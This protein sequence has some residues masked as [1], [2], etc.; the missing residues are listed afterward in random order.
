MA[1]R[2]YQIT[3]S[4]EIGKGGAKTK[5]KANLA[6]VRLLKE[7]EAEQRQATPD[8]QA[9]L[10]KFSGWGTVVDIFTG[11]PEWA[12]LQGEL[13]DLLTDA[14]YESASAAILN[15]HYTA[16]EVTTAI[17]EGLE[18]LGFDGGKILDPSMG[19]TGVFEGTLPDSLQEESK[20]VGIELDSLSGRIARKLYPE[21]AIHIRGFEKTVL[22]DDSFDLA[23]SNVPFSEVGVSDPE[24]D[25]LPV[26]TLHDYFFVK[27][28]D[29]VRPG[30]LTAFITSIGTMQSGSSE[31]VRELLSERANLVGAMRLPGTAFKQVAGTEVTTDLIVLQK[32]GDGVEPNGVDWTKLQPS[33]V[34]GA[35]GNALPVNEYYARNPQMMLGTLADDKLYPGRLAL[36]GD[37]RDIQ[38]AMRE[39]FSSFPEGIYQSAS[40]ATRPQQANILIPPDLQDR[41]KPDA[42][43]LHEDQLMRRMGHYLKPTEL[44]GK[45]LE[46]MKGMLAIRDAVQSVF[47]VQLQGGS[48]QALQEAQAT[49][50]QTYDD[51]TKANGFIHQSAN[52][53]IF[54]KDPDYPLLLALENYDAE[55]KTATKT[56]IFSDR[57]IQAH[58]EKTEADTPKEA[59][60]YSL[61]ERGRVD[62]DYIAGL[63]D[64]SSA[65]VTQALQ[66]EKLIFLDPQK[67][68]WVAEDEYL[69]GN[70]KEKLRIA[71]ESAAEDPRYAVNVEALE[72]VQP[73]LIPPG[74]IEVRLGAAWVPPSDVQDF[75]KH[76]LEATD[77][78]NIQYSPFLDVWSVDAS[79]QVLGSVKNTKVYGTERVGALRLIELGLNLKDPVV[80]DKVDERLVVNQED[81]AA[82]RM[83]LEE[84]KVAFKDWVWQ[85]PARTERLTDLYNEKFNTFRPRQYNGAHL[86]LP[87][88]NPAIQ[89]RPHQKNATWRVLQ[90][91]NSLLAH[92]VGAGKTFSVIAAAM[93]QKR[94]GLVNK[95]MVVV[96]NHLLEQW[97]GDFKRLYPNS[98]ILAATKDDSSAKNRQE[99]MS[100]IATGNWDAVIVTHSA[101]S[102]LKM[103]KDAQLDFYHAELSQVSE[104]ASEAKGNGS[105]RS[106]IKEFERQKK[107]LQKR[108]DEISKSG[109]DD[110]VTFEQLGVDQVYID[111]A[112]YFKNLGYSTKM[113]GIAGLPNTTSDRAFDLFM[114][115]RYLGAQHGESKGVVFATGTPVSNSMA[116]L[117]TMQRYLQPQ[118]LRQIGL[119][120]FDAW[121]S[122]FGETV[123][124]PEITPAGGY[125][126]KTRFSRF[127]NIP[128]LM[129]TFRQVADIQT[130][131]MLKLPVPELKGGKPEVVAVPATDMQLAFVEELA[132]RAE[133][134]RDVDPRDDNMLLI[135][136]DGRKASLDMR[137]VN[138]YVS[139]E[140]NKVDQLIEDTCQFWEETKDQKTTHLIFCDMGTPKEDAGSKTAK[141]INVE[142]QFTVYGYIKDGLIARGIPAS[143]IA[144]AQE[145]KTDAKKLEMQQKFN[146]GKI[147]VLISGSQLETGF[148]GQKK[149]GLESHLTVPWRPDQVEQRDGR[150]LR[151][152]NENPEVQVRR[153]VTQGRGGRPSFDSY[154]W[155][156]LETKKK[157]IAQ[158]MAGNSEVRTMEDVA[159]AALTYAEVKAIATGNPLIM[160]KA[161]VDNQISLLAA[162]K[163]S[164]L[165]QQYNTSRELTRLPERIDEIQET[166][167]ALKADAQK[168]PNLA[169]LSVT[170][171]GV[172]FTDLREAMKVVKAR[173]LEKQTV[174][175]FSDESIGQVGNFDLGLRRG[176]KDELNLVVRGQQDYQCQIEHTYVGTATNLTELLKSF[177]TLVHKQEKYLTENKKRLVELSEYSDVPFSKESELRAAL[178]RQSEINTELGLS[179]DNAQAA[180]EAE[181]EGAESESATPAVTTVVP[182]PEVQEDRSPVD[183]SN[184]SVLPAAEQQGRIE[185]RIAT[186]LDKAGIREA[187]TAGEDFHLEIENEPYIPLVVERHSDELYLAHYLQQNGDSFIDS[188]MVFSIKD[189]GQL[190]LKETATQNPF[191]GGESRGCDR[192][193]AQVFSRNVQTQGFG[194]AA[195][196]Q[197]QQPQTVAVQAEANSEEPQAAETQ[198]EEVQAVEPENMPTAEVPV[199]ETVEPEDTPAAEAQAEEIAGPENT[200][201]AEEVQS[202]KEIANPLYQRYRT[203]KEKTPEAIVFVQTPI[204]YQTFGQDAERYAEITGASLS[205]TDTQSGQLSTVHTSGASLERRT[206][207]VTDQ[208]IAI[209]VV[210]KDCTV[211]LH[212][213][214]TTVENSA[215][216]L[217]EPIEP[218]SAQPENPDTPSLDVPPID[219]LPEAVEAKAT[220][221][222]LDEDSALLRY[223]QGSLSLLPKEISELQAIFQ[224]GNN[225]TEMKESIEQ[226]FDGAVPPRH[227]EFL[228]DAVMSDLQTIKA[229]PIEASSEAVAEEIATPI[230]TD[231]EVQADQ[232]PTTLATFPIEDSLNSS[233]DEA[234]ETELDRGE[235]ILKIAAQTYAFMETQG[236]VLP[237]EALEMW[238]AQGN[239]YDI[240]YNPDNANFFVEGKG[241]SEMVV[242]SVDSRI[243]PDSTGAVS[244]ADVERF[245]AI[246]QALSPHVF[247][248]EQLPAQTQA[249][250]QFKWESAVEAAA[251][252]SLSAAL[253]SSSVVSDGQN[254]FPVEQYASESPNRSESSA[255]VDPSWEQLDKQ[256]ALQPVSSSLPPQPVIEGVSPLTNLTTENSLAVAHSTLVDSLQ[257]WRQ[258][259][260]DLDHSEKYL[261]RIEELISE[262]RSSGAEQLTDKAAAAMGHDL[263]DWQQQ[264]AT[265][266]Q[267]AQFILEAIGK[268]DSTGT[269]YEGTTYAIS[270]S[271]EGS[272]LSI[273]ASGSPILQVE[274]DKVQHC[275]VTAADAERFQSFVE[276]VQ[277]ATEAIEK[278]PIAAGIER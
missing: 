63:V 107:R 126:V 188:E 236:K 120:K 246:E 206:E 10:V 268:A 186:F 179:K 6:A 262:V 68:Q 163:R 31:G 200:P 233:P 238:T 249:I 79:Y 153:Y 149:L 39:A 204:S 172:A 75:A 135:T 113:Y 54:R 240:T 278:Q 8:E 218:A 203:Q 99:L 97:A 67:T 209:A 170:V 121:A 231:G 127:V 72:A 221:F 109:K 128:E 27:A 29:K 137:L 212:Q 101:F 176:W 252:V 98:N 23:I 222:L 255:G 114:K 166:I 250:A 89:L 125:K 254:L 182:V 58:Q 92:C 220:G 265:V 14:E 195:R 150:I 85:D 197:L 38:A 184:L 223:E 263:K 227:M 100:R 9:V 45:K 40:E 264:V 228:V 50:N 16:P 70:V 181:E 210:E 235:A 78:L 64:Q 37:G 69:S 104:A 162:Q 47:A 180:V 198:A 207:Q 140:R 76:L 156:T 270:Q 86:D 65:E 111:E 145:F 147:R 230:N 77:F 32:L 168:V 133:N 138:P 215:A 192:I 55:T 103:S 56:A 241:G 60:L 219:S 202:T 275:S 183:L 248:R 253:V 272:R 171:Q 74:D 24:Y 91:G 80:Y 53:Q 87:G 2:N 62:L 211:R 175:D 46:R 144:F 117:Y 52:K 190:Q 201:A 105:S 26:K 194:E 208:G 4:D 258:Q 118:A 244:Q 242:Q 119:S 129:N 169:S 217:I 213:P 15:A 261:A 71:Q 214:S 1:N 57:V 110:A 174:K 13:K 49:L 19:A 269:H 18:Q 116:E 33:T 102:R 5:A 276:K 257:Q 131:E 277:Q 132:E 141:Q 34:T 152:G 205:K 155:Q 21:A 229:Q 82:A 96:P 191:Q 146:A 30:G 122:T 90:E 273:E 44:E 259:A 95:P 266:T 139:H 160:E 187:V 216:E 189:D 124:A 35:D 151:Q 88:S 115:C 134:L 247:E 84:I 173:V 251:S 199:V 81:T 232:P 36:K 73:P 224:S 234:R 42:Y 66:Q 167:A 159:G 136:T 243:D 112:H 237:D 164:H 158:V 130:A 239:H 274:G 25:G 226:L 11:K 196:E 260:Q 142:K 161:T 225:D 177:E 143:E 28:L 193:F 165:N 245:Q 178:K 108:V 59:L 12:T 17:Y 123:T 83:K 256:V 48:E 93:E 267:Q 61:N 94:L 148:N 20:I 41:V 7:L 22:P 106:M 3:T 185:K 51:F 154:M 271:P 157:F 43:V